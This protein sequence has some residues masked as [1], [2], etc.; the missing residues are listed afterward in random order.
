MDDWK[1]CGLRGKS[2]RI[3]MIAALPNVPSCLDPSAIVLAKESQKL[4]EY[5]D[6]QHNYIAFSCCHHPFIGG[7]FSTTSNLFGHEN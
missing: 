7:T 1:A 2:H 3:T 5:N 4:N 6:I